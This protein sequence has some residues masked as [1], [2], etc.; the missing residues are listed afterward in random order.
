M[1]TLDPKARELIALARRAEQPTLHD[2]QRVRRRISAALGGATIAA[3]AHRALDSSADA[4]GHS[5]SGAA[6]ANSAGILGSLQTLHAAL[7]VAAGT[8]IG[9]VTWVVV[10]SRDSAEPP[11]VS[12]QRGGVTEVPSAPVPDAESSGPS[13]I[14]PEDLPMLPVETAS[15][16]VAA[17]PTAAKARSSSREAVRRPERRVS[18]ADEARELVAVHRSLRDG[19]F[20]AALSRLDALDRSP[21]S[22]L[23]EERLAARVLALCGLERRTEAESVA[24]RFQAL[25]PESPLLPR[26]SQSCAGGVLPAAESR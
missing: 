4:A 20:Q 9:G 3:A 13:P 5:V 17:P 21:A 6:A 16:P 22:A 8:L 25:A 24:A 26:L 7:W 12:V 18:L 10:A 1:N 2:R 19:S 14:Q 11:A 23:R 15:A